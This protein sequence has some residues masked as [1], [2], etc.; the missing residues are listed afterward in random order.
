[1]SEFDLTEEAKAEKSITPTQAYDALYQR[2]LKTSRKLT[3]LESLITSY[4]PQ[5]NEET[6]LR[7]ML[8]DI[9]N[10]HNI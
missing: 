6:T 9:I 3:A 2:F 7:D 1:M 5:S 8:L 4:H 10:E